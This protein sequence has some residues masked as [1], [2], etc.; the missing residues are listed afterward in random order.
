MILTAEPPGEQPPL[1][2]A[3]D[4]ILGTHR[5]TSPRHGT[6]KR[7]DPAR[8]NPSHQHRILAAIHPEPLR[9]TLTNPAVPPAGILAGQPQDQGLDVP[10]GRWP[11][12]LAAPGPGGHRRRTM[13]RCQRRIVSGVTSSR[14][15]WLRAFGITPSRAAGSARPAQSRFGRRGCCRCR[16]VSWWRRIKISAVFHVSSR[17]D[18]RDHA[19]SR[20]VT[21]NMNRRHMTV[22]HHG[23]TAGVATLLVRAMDEILGTHRS[24]PGSVGRC[25]RCLNTAGFVSTRSG[26]ACSDESDFWPRSVGSDSRNNS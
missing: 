24:R 3:V 19:A 22:D 18:R 11:A 5:T 26:P 15:P 1:V 8:V 9:H 23:G 20:V 6:P 2:R 12:G 13:S 16:T 25:G 14:S 4:E 7:P 10:A 17:R 21:R